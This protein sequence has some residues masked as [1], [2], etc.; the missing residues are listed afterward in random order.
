MTGE[1]SCIMLKVL[2][3]KEEKEDDNEGDEG[4]TEDSWL[5]DLWIGE[6]CYMSVAYSF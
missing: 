4:K 6:I 3:K 5:I 2:H 1:H